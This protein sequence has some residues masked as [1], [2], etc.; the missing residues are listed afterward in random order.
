MI[1][2]L[3][4]IAT[5]LVQTVIRGWEVVPGESLIFF[6]QIMINMRKYRVCMKT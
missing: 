2:H 3:R 1:F 5:T 4:A 6:L